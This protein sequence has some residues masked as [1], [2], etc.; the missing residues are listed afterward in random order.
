[1]LCRKSY[2]DQREV[3]LSVYRDWNHWTCCCCPSVFYS[4]NCMTL[5]FWLPDVYYSLCILTESLIKYKMDMRAVSRWFVQELI[6][7]W[8]TSQ[9]D[10]N[11]MCRCKGNTP[12]DVTPSHAWFLW[13]CRF[14]FRTKPF[15]YSNWGF[16]TISFH[17]GPIRTYHCRV[18]IFP[19]TPHRLLNLPN[20][21]R[22]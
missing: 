22:F 20:L 21:E 2:L 3:F 5:L 14:C 12:H 9:I 7:A 19:N 1:M 15:Y 8:N 4:D 10:V 16:C 6:W 11:Q 13:P 17:K 18:G